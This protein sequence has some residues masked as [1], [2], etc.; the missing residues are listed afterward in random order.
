MHRLLAET[1]R[2]RT[3]ACKNMQVLPRQGHLHGEI[4]SPSCGENT[5]PDSDS[6]TIQ[7]SGQMELTAAGF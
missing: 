5:T 6:V 7:G 2:S 1:S 4:R 3:E